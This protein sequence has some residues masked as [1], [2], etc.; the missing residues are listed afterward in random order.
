MT[1]GSNET[2][3]TSTAPLGTAD[4]EPPLPGGSYYT[5]LPFW[6]QT[7]PSS[8]GA[9]TPPARPSSPA[10]PSPG[11]G[12]GDPFP[13]MVRLLLTGSTAEAESVLSW[14]GTSRAEKQAYVPHLLALLPSEQLTQ[15]RGFLVVDGESA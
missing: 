6:S 13:D 10:P 5:P 8:G 14:F 12:Q 4:D 7:P 15:A 9:L 2:T 1:P 11:A 3:Q